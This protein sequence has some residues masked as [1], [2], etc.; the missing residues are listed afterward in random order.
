MSSHLENS[1]IAPPYIDGY[2]LLRRVGVGSYGEVWLAEDRARVHRAVKI[3]RRSSFD[4]ERPYEREYSG[5]L[6]F[7][8]VSRLH[9]S[10]VAVLE[11]GRSDAEGFFYYVME[12]ADSAELTPP[13]EPG[14][15]SGQRHRPLD[16]KTYRP[17]NLRSEI[18]RHGRLD[19]EECL[20]TGIAL[21]TALDHLH[22]H[23][24]IHRDI[25]PSNVIFVGG[26]PKLADIGLVTDSGA[27]ATFVGTEGFLPPEG[28][29]TESADI[30]ALGKVLYEMS[31]GRDRMDFPELPTLID[32]PVGD[33]QSLFELNLVLLKACQND[34][35][36]RY[37]SVRELLADLAVLN[38]GGS[39]RR[40]RSLELRVQSVRRALMGGAALVAVAAAVWGYWDLRQS[41]R[42]AELIATAQR[43]RDL[44]A[45]ATRDTRERLKL[46]YLSRAR[47]ATEI[48]D[49]SGAAVWL[50]NAAELAPDPVTAAT[51]QSNVMSRL[52]SPFSFQAAAFVAMGTRQL[53]S[54]AGQADRLALF[55]ETNFMVINA[56]R[57]ATPFFSFAIPKG[58]RAAAASDRGE[59]IAIL[60]ETG[61][62]AYWTAS[63][64]TWHRID[65]ATA[66][67]W[68]AVDA[69]GRSLVGMDA[70]GH[71]SAWETS[72]GKRSLRFDHGAPGTALALS[73]DGRR[74]AT[75]GTDGWVRLWDALNGQRQETGLGHSSSVNQILFAPRGDRLVTVEGKVARFWETSSGERG[76][77]LS[78]DTPIGAVCFTP[79]GESLITLCLDGSVRV[80]DAIEASL[81]QPVRFV[82]SGSGQLQVSPDS[83]WM[84]VSVGRDL[85]VWDLS[86]SPLSLVPAAAFPGRG[87]AWG[88]SV[89]ARFLHC[90]DELGLLSRWELSGASPVSAVGTLTQVRSLASL[91][92][93]R[94]L[95]NEQLSPLPMAVGVRLRSDLSSAVLDSAFVDAQPSASW[96][97]AQAAVAELRGRWNA[98]RFHW[99]H[100]IEAGDD[101]AETARHREESIERSRAGEAGMRSLAATPS[102]PNRASTCGL[103][104]LDLSSFYTATLLGSWLPANGVSAPNDLAEFAEIPHRFGGLEFDAR[105]VIQLA[106]TPLENQ[107]KRFARA[108]AGIPVGQLA[109]RLHFIQGTVGD[110][111]RRTEVGRYVV[112]YKDGKI[113]E[114]PLLYGE[115]I[116]DWWCSSN[117]PRRFSAAAVIWQGSNEA[118]RQ[119]GF[120][121]RLFQA[122]WINPRL[123]EPIESIEFQSA[124]ERSAPFLLAI[125]V[126]SHPLDT[127]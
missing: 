52:Q 97:R 3:V 88:F 109:A 40:Q 35:K 113:A 89:D 57:P 60:D 38:G 95:I 98:A 104:Q 123:N 19:I 91:L 67:R 15:A 61:A 31:T 4:S 86:Q 71:V 9:A 83:R 41:Q 58:F 37:P 7:E 36:K 85:S 108:V 5:I 87:S 115:N 11:V 90:I 2:R 99:E 1:G 127:H 51:I 20:R 76:R 22:R 103:A 47:E 69:Q 32:N 56:N 45:Q 119:L 126:E 44:Q 62:L 72:Q 43:D 30:Y 110:V 75:A 111:V 68:I 122:T 101:A 116:G 102:Y 14:M 80:W 74:F 24:L 42:A 118:S 79:D 73:R 82:N 93:G 100:A 92:A 12:L 106:S 63:D 53:R 117:A 64:A 107:G 46:I 23:G 114:I 125:T 70:A 120:N 49:H 94:D 84:G 21:A 124:M 28:P 27:T 34:P 26:V 33:G 105:G 25:K 121:V 6:K 66:L 65:E 17:K 59:M 54:G 112:H 81:R 77:S 55:S 18:T 8:P 39:L 13:M 78:H 48:A 16:P 50:A 10:Q 29:G 96:H